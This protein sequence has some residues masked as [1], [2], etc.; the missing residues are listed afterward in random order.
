MSKPPVPGS[1]LYGNVV[2]FFRRIKMLTQVRDTEIPCNAV[3]IAEDIEL[4]GHLFLLSLLPCCAQLA[5]PYWAK[6][7]GR[8]FNQRTDEVL[9]T[10]K[11]TLVD[12]VGSPL[13]AYTDNVALESGEKG[14][15]EVKLADYQTES[16][17]YRLAIEETDLGS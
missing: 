9:L 13:A 15:F 3:E 4:Q 5:L 10:V 12:G 7:L 16:A 17:A 6:I 1:N 8:V 14:E 11:V 2:D